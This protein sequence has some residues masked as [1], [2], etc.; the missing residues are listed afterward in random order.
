MDLLEFTFVL[1]KI[2][3]F[4]RNIR[5]R[6]VKKPKIYFFDLGLR[7]AVL[8]NF[9]DLASRQDSG[10]LFENF[11]FLE[12]KNR[13]K[14]RIFFYRTIAKTEIDFIV[15]KGEKIILAEVKYKN[16]AKTIDSRIIQNFIEREGNIA[17]AAV[18]NLSFNGRDNSIEYID[19]RFA[20][21][22][23]DIDNSNIYLPSKLKRDII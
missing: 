13:M 18:I 9:L 1:D 4:R 3:P 19:Y 8:G 17:K 16:L 11:I 14:D 15:E 22:V 10:F 12:F 5:A 2:S 7:N 21:K 23:V 6:L 20:G